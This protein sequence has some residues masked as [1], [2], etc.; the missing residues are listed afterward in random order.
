MLHFRCSPPWDEAKEEEE[1]ADVVLP[2]LFAAPMTR[3]VASA[4][5]M[6]RSIW[7]GTYRSKHR[8]VQGFKSN[9]Q[10][11]LHSIFNLINLLNVL[12]H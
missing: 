12:H 1:E 10:S 9:F 6:M 3:S 8:L 2:L 5:L 4:A 11:L 7:I